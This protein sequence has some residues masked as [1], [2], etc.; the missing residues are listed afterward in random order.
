MLKDLLARNLALKLLAV[1]L[2]G[3]LWFV[4]KNG[5]IK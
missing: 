4:A 3:L 5:L 2:A 1:A